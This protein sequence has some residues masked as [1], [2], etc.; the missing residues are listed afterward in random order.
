MVI[1][2]SPGRK[3]VPMDSGKSP[4]GKCQFSFGWIHQLHRHWTPGI[5]KCAEE[6]DAID[7]DSI[8]IAHSLG[9]VAALHYCIQR[10]KT[11]EILVLV[12]IAGFNGRLG[13]L[14]EVNPF[15]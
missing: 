14:D 12:L 5:S 3:L 7:E 8:F 15:Y 6:I 2:V 9:T 4:T 13:R 10:I 11:A 1:S